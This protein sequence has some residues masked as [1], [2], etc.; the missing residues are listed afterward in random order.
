M[1]GAMLMFYNTRLYRSI[2]GSLQIIRTG[3]DA[4]IAEI[5][6]SELVINFRT[7]MIIACGCISLNSQ[8]RQEGERKYFRTNDWILSRKVARYRSE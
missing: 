1:D 6:A 8:L 7:Y 3:I 2:V 5:A 4:F